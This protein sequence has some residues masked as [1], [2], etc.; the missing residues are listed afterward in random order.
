MLYYYMYIAL[1]VIRL[2]V[3]QVMQ[4]QEAVFA[5]KRVY[6]YLD[7]RGKEIENY[8]VGDV[9]L[10]ARRIGAYLQVGISRKTY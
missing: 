10:Y 4:R 8:S 3:P 2:P 5:D 7:N 6:T 9:L 1:T